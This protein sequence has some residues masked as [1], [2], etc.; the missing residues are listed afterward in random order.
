MSMQSSVAALRV[1]DILSIVFRLIYPKRL[2]L[3]RANFAKVIRG[4]FT[5]MNLG[6]SQIARYGYRTAD[7]GKT[8][9][10]RVIKP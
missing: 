4:L 2:C 1:D 5:G 3:L 10:Q 8:H 6:R 9:V 7:F